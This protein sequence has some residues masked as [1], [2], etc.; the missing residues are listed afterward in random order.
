VIYP[1]KILFSGRNQETAPD[2]REQKTF[3]IFSA[4]TKTKSCS[5]ETKAIVDD[6]FPLP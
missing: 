6:Y 1:R 3:W 4:D 2:R 5:P